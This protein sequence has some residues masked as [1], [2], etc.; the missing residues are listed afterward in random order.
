M[1]KQSMNDAQKLSHTRKILIDLLQVCYR[2][3]TTDDHY[4]FIAAS[5]L[6]DVSLIL[7]R[8]KY[9][10]IHICIDDADSSLDPVDVLRYL[11]G[12]LDQYIWLKFAYKHST[13]PYA[14]KTVHIEWD[15]NKIKQAFPI[16]AGQNN[17][18]TDVGVQEALFDHVHV[19]G[20]LM[21]WLAAFNQQYPDEDVTQERWEVVY[22]AMCRAREQRR[23]DA[24]N[25]VM[26]DWECARKLLGKESIT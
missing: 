20:D 16:I 21:P 17:K 10:A 23:S 25:W 26:Q 11:N 8:L 1:L 2:N 14:A 6:A 12:Y 13:M 18:F 5:A 7:E 22:A 3:P 4:Y 9:I 15:R 19:P 24:T